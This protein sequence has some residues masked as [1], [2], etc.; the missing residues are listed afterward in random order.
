MGEHKKEFKVTMLVDGKA[1]DS[2]IPHAWACF[3][4]GHWTTEKPTKPGKY[5][6]ANTQGRV[7]G[8]VFVFWQEGDL[9]VQVR[10]GAFCRLRNLQGRYFW[11]SARMPQVM[12][13]RVPDMESLEEAVSNRPKLTLVV[14]NS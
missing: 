2:P 7:L 12:P 1:K 5:M 4:N 8:E 14:S 6:I 11:W 9:S 3:L 13:Q 10:D